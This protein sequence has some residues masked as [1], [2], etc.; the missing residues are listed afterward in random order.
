MAVKPLASTLASEVARLKS[1]KEAALAAVKVSA[2]IKTV[3][4]DYKE[5]HEQLATAKA[6]FLKLGDMLAD[7]PAPVDNSAAIAVLDAAKGLKFDALKAK[8]ESDAAVEGSLEKIVEGTAVVFDKAAVTAA[9]TYEALIGYEYAARVGVAFEAGDMA[10]VA[11]LGPEKDQKIADF[12]AVF[13]DQIAALSAAAPAAAAAGV[14]YDEAQIVAVNDSLDGIRDA[15]LP[16]F[17]DNCKIIDH[18]ALIK[19]G[20]IK[21]GYVT[22]KVVKDVADQVLAA[23][24]DLDTLPDPEDTVEAWVGKLQATVWDATFGM[25]QEEFDSLAYNLD[26][27][28]KTEAVQIDAIGQALHGLQGLV[29]APEANG[30]IAFA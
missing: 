9:T 4:Q 21:V 24:A 10:A 11:V 5:L 18:A 14:A 23:L 25:L 20:K 27:F 7:A 6:A 26:L 1:G 12:K 29:D 28:A 22:K 15:G 19:H 8:L 13:D 30:D 17:S 16:L 2:S 3:Y